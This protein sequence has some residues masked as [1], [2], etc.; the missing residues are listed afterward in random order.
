MFFFFQLIAT[1]EVF[2]YLMIKSGRY[3]LCQV[4]QE[5]V[6]IFTLQKSIVKHFFDRKMGPPPLANGALCLSTLKHNG[7]SGT[8][9][10]DMYSDY[11]G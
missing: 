11:T 1:M 10:I 9:S 8:G 7:K 5:K 6:H 3:A 4:N 2:Q